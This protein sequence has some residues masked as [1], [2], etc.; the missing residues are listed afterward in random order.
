MVRTPVVLDKDKFVLVKDKSRTPGR[1]M[2]KGPLDLK[3]KNHDLKVKFLSGSIS[4]VTGPIPMK[5]KDRSASYC[6]C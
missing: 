3:V 4:K 1:L 6:S 5:L 2:V